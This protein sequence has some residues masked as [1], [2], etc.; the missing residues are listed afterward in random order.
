MSFLFRRTLCRRWAICW[1]KRTGTDG[2]KHN[3]WEPP[4]LKQFCFACNFLPC[5]TLCSVMTTLKL[6]S[7]AMSEQ[8]T[9]VF[10]D[11]QWWG[12]RTDKKIEIALAN[13]ELSQ[14]KRPLFHLLHPSVYRWLCQDCH[15]AGIGEALN[16]PARLLKPFHK[17]VFIFLKQK[18]TKEFSINHHL[19]K[20]FYNTC[21]NLILFVFKYM[22]LHSLY[23]NNMY[24]WLLNLGENKSHCR[25][26]QMLNKT[27]LLSAAKT[28]VLTP[29][30]MHI[31]RC[32]RTCNQLIF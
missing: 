2:K 5:W 11:R 23:L 30:L 6:M 1:W 16:K 17:P 3:W 25:P 28:A 21:I 15:H 31:S 18:S 26:R 22:Y 19:F 32:S 27:P 7:E 20:P 4:S 13:E 8:P 24:L 10:S 9:C 14:G 12:E 29:Y